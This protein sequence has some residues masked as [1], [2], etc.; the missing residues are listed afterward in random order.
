MRL[1]FVRHGES[2]ANV[3]HQISNR[4]LK[5][6]LTNTGRQQAAALAEKLSPIP[7][8]Q[9][10]ASPV[11]RAVQTAE[12]LS[13]TLNVPFEITDALREYDC[14]ILEGQSDPDSWAAHKRNFEDWLLRKQWDHHIEGGESFLD[15]Q[16]RFVPFIQSLIQKYASSEAHVVLVGHGGTYACMLPLVLTNI[17]HRFMRDLPYGFGYTTLIQTELQPTGLVC[18]EWNGNRL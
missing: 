9:I 12:I 14:G 16:A 18:L 1:Y 5:H 7:V 10:Y 17:D 15:I 2:E 3:L 8:T 6:E 4:G 13:T 11:L